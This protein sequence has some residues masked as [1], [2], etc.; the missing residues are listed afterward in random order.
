MWLAASTQLELKMI[1]A[2]CQK[3]GSE[4]SATGLIPHLTTTDSG[5][6]ANPEKQLLLTG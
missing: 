3:K 5:K 1:G 4:P 6:A 2:T